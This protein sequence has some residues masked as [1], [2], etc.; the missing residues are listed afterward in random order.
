MARAIYI[1]VDT[2]I[3][4][5][6]LADGLFIPSDHSWIRGSGGGEIVLGQACEPGRPSKNEQKLNLNSCNQEFAAEDERRL[7]QARGGEV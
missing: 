7:L 2:G 5:R 1:I 6:F 3:D 4:V